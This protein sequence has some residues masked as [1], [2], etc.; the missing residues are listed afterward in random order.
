MASTDWLIALLLF[1]ATLIPIVLT[2]SD[3][4]LTYDEPI[5][6]GA[7]AKVAEWL[8]LTLRSACAGD[9]SSPFSA[10]TI[11]DYWSAKDMQPATVKYVNALSVMLLQPLLGY[12]AAIRFGSGFMLSLCVAALY[13]WSAR[14]Y[15]RRA[16]VVGAMSLVLMPRLWGHAHFTTCDV[17]VATMSFL[18]VVSVWWL[19]QV[20]RLTSA[21]GEQREISRERRRPA[22]VPVVWATFITGLVAGLAVGTKMNAVV[23]Y[24]VLLPWALTQGRRGFVR[25]AIALLAVAPMIFF[26]S[27]PWLWVDPATRLG[28][29][30][31]FQLQHYKIGATYFGKTYVIPPWHYPFVMTAITTPI[32]TLALAVVGSVRVNRMAGD[33]RSTRTRSESAARL[34]ILCVAVQLTVFAMPGVPRYNGV[35]LFLSAFPFM[36][37]LAGIGYDR[38]AGWVLGWKMLDIAEPQKGSDSQSPSRLRKQI[39]FVVAAVCLLPGFT[40]IVTYHPYELSYYNSLVGGLPGAVQRGFE[41]T[42]WGDTYVKALSFL[43][44]DAP[45]GAIINVWPPG[46]VSYFEMYQRSG[47]LRPDLRFTAGDSAM[48]T[49]DYVVF[50]TRQSE[51]SGSPLAVKLFREGKPAFVVEHLGVPLNVV[52]GHSELNR[53]LGA[54]TRMRSPS[55]D[56]R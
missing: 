47:A 49:A 56:I 31:R 26:L 39:A 13:L 8:R 20:A 4:G 37:M 9:V 36:A 19:A 54:G 18:M 50:H 32:A 44:R 41:P 10:S 15:S 38:L 33:R 3:I 2:A 43:N 22:I 25:V 14:V 7:S 16:G 42:Y 6:G 23:S 35:R 5:Y 30:L 48:R 34:L 45:D 53:V 21:G 28:E 51:M 46:V 27:W 1:F 11:D 29:Y 17:P 24:G 52:Y 40:G 55:E 12:L